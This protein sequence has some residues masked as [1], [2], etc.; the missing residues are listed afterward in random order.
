MDIFIISNNTG[1]TGTAMVEE[2]F[3]ISE[4]LV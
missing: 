4:E 2:W 3:A 1:D